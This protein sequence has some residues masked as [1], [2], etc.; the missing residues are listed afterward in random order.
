MAAIMFALFVLFLL[1]R[2]RSRAISVENAVIEA[3]K[4]VAQ[5]FKEIV[6]TG[7]NIGE[8]EQ[9]SGEK[10]HDL[11]ARVLEVEGLERF[12]LSS[13]EPNTITDELIRSFKS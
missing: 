7:V 9:A 3:K 1:R 11:V 12:R 2:G 13:V 8:Y 5:G 10:L 6:L 4:L